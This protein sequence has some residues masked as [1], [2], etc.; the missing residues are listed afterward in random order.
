MTPGFGA[1]MTPGAWEMAGGVCRANS[2]EHLFVLFVAGSFCWS[3][4]NRVPFKT[5]PTRLPSKK[6]K[7]PYEWAGLNQDIL[8]ETHPHAVRSASARYRLLHI[9][10][11]TD[12]SIQF[13]DYALRVARIFDAPAE[14]FNPQLAALTAE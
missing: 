3:P 7:H 4:Q 5:S 12:K 9:T 2:A 14:D 8:A 1:A 10:R 13:A 11:S 6:R